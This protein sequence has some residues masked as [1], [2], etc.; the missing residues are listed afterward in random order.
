MLCWY[1]QGLRSQWMFPVWFGS[2]LFRGEFDVWRRVIPEVEARI[3]WVVEAAVV[4]H[5]PDL[6]AWMAGLTRRAGWVV[7][8][9]PLILAGGESFKD[10][11]RGVLEVLDRLKED[12]LC[13]HS[14]LLVVGGGAFLDGVG[15]AGA[16]WHRG[17]RLI[18]V[19]T[20]LLAQADSGVGVKNAINGPG[21]KNIIGTFSV[22]H[23]VLNDF[24]FLETLPVEH[25]REGMTEALKVGLI[26]DREFFDW[27]CGEVDALVGGER[28]AVEF[29]VRRCA[30]THLRHIAE[31]GDP[32][33][34]GSARPLDFGH[35]VGHELE[36]AS[37][38]QIRHGQGVAIGLGVDTGYA[39]AQGWLPREA[40]VRLLSVLRRLEL[41]V[42]HPLLEE[43]GEKGR[44]IFE[45][46]DRF[47]EHLGGKLSLTFPDGLG[48]SRQVDRVDQTV[49]KRIMDEL[50]EVACQ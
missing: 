5:H 32:F 40:W 49:M 36:R 41:P 9:E 21:G 28:A 46:L 19:P 45:G 3:L 24:D 37:D 2:G 42:W 30:E 35:W 22:P 7:R 47:R 18:R 34:M 8:G 20:T 12:R 31:G 29:L 6:P 15:L 11:W 23:A 33:E 26:K 17:V 39:V 44:V 10:G 16:L 27:L 48:N 43:E 50:K 25:L 38:Y 1:E 13:R 4:E 14:Y